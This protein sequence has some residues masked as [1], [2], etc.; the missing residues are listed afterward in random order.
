MAISASGKY[1]HESSPNRSLERALRL[2]TVVAEAPRGSTLVAA[3]RAAELAPSTASRLLGTLERTGFVTRCEHGVYRAG[4]ELSRLGRLGELE[5]SLPE[6][7]QPI[8]DRLA[9]WTGESSYLAVAV[10]DR[11]AAY[12]ASAP[13]PRSIRHVS[14]GDSPVPRRGSAAGAV[15]AGAVAPYDTVTV[16]DGVEDDTTA[17]ATPVLLGGTV[18]A[19]LNVVAPT[20]R[21]GPTET[22][23]ISACVLRAAAELH[24]ALNKL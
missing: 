5:R 12:A 24:D 1:P 2:L 21:A 20:F 9:M 15:L 11:W 4:P 7:A 14:W 6:L 23:A 13:S 17:V 22:E 19:A 3:A 18:V 8:L 16:S 10:D